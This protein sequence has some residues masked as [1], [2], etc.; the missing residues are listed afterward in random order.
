M[1]SSGL[2][3]N[4]LKVVPRASR[5]FFKDGRPFLRS[6]NGDSPCIIKI[7]EEEEYLK[8]MFQRAGGR[9]EPVQEFKRMGFREVP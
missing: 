3:C 4:Q 8:Q 1:L 7:T 6:K 2:Q 9:C 5:P